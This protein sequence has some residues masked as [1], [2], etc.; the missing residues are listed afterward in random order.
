MKTKIYVLLD[1]NGKI[2]YVGKTGEALERRL[3]KDLG[4]AKR[5]GK[6]HKCN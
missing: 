4:E 5:G 1:P 2:R 6:T 3:R